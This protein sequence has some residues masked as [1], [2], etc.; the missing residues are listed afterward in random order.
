ML[1]DPRSRTNR[2]HSWRQSPPMSR[3]GLR[4]ETVGG[5]QFV[6]TARLPQH[7]LRS[8]ALPLAAPQR[9]IN[10]APL[11]KLLM[12]PTLGDNALVEH[13]NLVGVDHSREAMGDHDR[14]ASAGD[15]LQ[16]RLNL[17]LG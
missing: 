16:R 11:Q 3:R 8:V 7:F 10:A 4:Q 2:A 17:T 14:R 1:I 12:R 5:A 13:Q 15:T 6:L 9:G